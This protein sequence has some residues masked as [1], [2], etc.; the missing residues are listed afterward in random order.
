MSN[1]PNIYEVCP[2]CKITRNTR[3]AP[4]CPICLDPFYKNTKKVEPRREGFQR[5]KDKKKY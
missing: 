5:G 1:L 3:T 4:Y 2:D